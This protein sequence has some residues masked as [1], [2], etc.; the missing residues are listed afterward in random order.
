MIPV[1]WCP[2]LNTFGLNN[3]DSRSRTTPGSSSASFGIRHKEK[4]PCVKQHN[5]IR[6]INSKVINPVDGLKDK[7]HEGEIS[8]R[9][10]LHMASLGLC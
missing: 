4:V 3:G 8:A 6:A 7:N 9:A 2:Q 5:V 10:Y 1:S